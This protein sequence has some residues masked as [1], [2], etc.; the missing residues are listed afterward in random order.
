MGTLETA[1]LL[2]IVGPTASGKSAL[3]MDLAKKFGGEIIAADSRTVYREMDIGTAKP[4]KQ[5]QKAVAHHLIDIKN[6]DEKFNASEFKKLANK[7]IAD[8]QKRG[9]LPILVGGSGLYIDSAIYDFQFNP[10]GTRDPLNP[11]HRLT[12]GERQSLSLRPNS[13]II[14]LDIDRETLRK[15]I[16]QRAEVMVGHGLIGETARL[17]KKYG[18]GIEALNATSYKPFA[19]YLNS[20]IDLVKAKRLFEA[21]D[22]ALAKRQKTWFKRNKSI[23]WVSNGEQAVELV[24]TFLNK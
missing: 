6:P 14:G 8:I 15:Q 4:S 3:A 1:P 24:T 12:S 19:Q 22:L 9:K 11:R 13:L 18:P 21:N 2:V 10:K 7:A 23:H 16:H 5:D 17:V 20:E